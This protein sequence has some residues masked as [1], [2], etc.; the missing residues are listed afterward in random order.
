[1]AERQTFL[2][3]AHA[4]AAV[5]KRIAWRLEACGLN[6]WM[7]SRKLRLGVDLDPTIQIHIK[8]SDTVLV[9]AT[10]A[11][12][13]SDW[14]KREVSYAAG[15]LPRPSICPIYI[16]NVQTH[17][18]FANF[19]GVIAT[20]PKDVEGA[21]ERVVEALEAPRSRPDP[22]SLQRH[23]D[24]LIDE[25]PD[26]RPLVETL[27]KGERTWA[28][29]VEAA[30][31][32]PFH[33][34]EF[35]INSLYDILGYLPSPHV[36]RAAADLFARRGVG[37]YVLAAYVS[38]DRDKFDTVLVDAVAQLLSPE[39][40]DTA[41][42]L[43]GQSARPDDHALCNLIGFNG[44]AFNERQW[45]SVVRLVTYPERGPG[46]FAINSA[47]QTMRR[48]P[49]NNAVLGLWQR[50]ISDGYFDGEAKGGEDPEYFARL[51]GDS[52]EKGDAGIDR[53]TRSF[54]YHIRNLVR[55][56][57]R[58]KVL[59]AVRHVWAATQAKSPLLKE[60]AEECS[61]GIGSA[62]WKDWEH[63][64]EMVLYVMC[65]VEGALTDGNLGRAQQEFEKS[66]AAKRR[67]Q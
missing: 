48:L 21:I 47:V 4:D 64:D 63:R 46:Q 30:A 28:H 7:D 17:K 41:I 20:A 2:S 1:M 52:I 26:L 43:L 42:W 39:S 59:M 54:L 57:E 11:S 58:K 6:V 32:A 24:V 65:H 34:V 8:N 66:W 50:W 27:L 16:E 33:A 29:H 23:L 36:P 15:L 60:I 53:I 49:D 61:S 35:A 62:E 18:L 25:E 13:Q 67:F 56:R 9:I 22:E 55:S 51:I 14:V 10:E 45:A 38:S 31:S 19:L 37:S 5:A 12:A 44:D 3:Y 40:L